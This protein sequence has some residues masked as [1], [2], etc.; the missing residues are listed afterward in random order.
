LKR[1]GVAASQAE[2][3]E[4]VLQR[5]QL[6]GAWGVVH[7]I[8]HRR[9]PPLQGLGGADV[10]LDHEFFDEFVRLQRDAHGDRRHLAV[11]AEDHPPFLGGD[12]ERGPP[13]AAFRQGSVGAPQRLQ[14]RIEQ[15]LRRRIGDAVDRRLGL[16]V[17]QARR[18]AHQGAFEPMRALLARGVEDHPHGQSRPRLAL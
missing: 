3:L 6:V 5:H 8:D 14:H 10:G 17:G 12:L 1:R 16:F 4:E 15:R 2:G 7:A 9:A 13:G 18:R 11:V